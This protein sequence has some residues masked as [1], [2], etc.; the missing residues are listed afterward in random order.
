MRQANSCNMD[1]QCTYERESM[2]SMF[3]LTCQDA[4]CCLDLTA[5]CMACALDIDTNKYCSKNKKTEA[6]LIWRD[7]HPPAEIKC[8]RVKD[9]NQCKSMD[10]C[11]WSPKKNNPKKGKCKDGPRPPTAAPTSPPDCPSIEGKKAC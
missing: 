8:K 11:Y 6:C 10:N 4:A 9:S 7:S 3:R 5:D 2:E 1:G